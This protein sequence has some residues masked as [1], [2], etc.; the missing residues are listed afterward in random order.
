MNFTYTALHSMRKNDCND[1]EYHEISLGQ[2][3]THLRDVREKN[4]TQI[5]IISPYLNDCHGTHMYAGNISI[6]PLQIQICVPS[7]ISFKK[8]Y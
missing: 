6:A 5:S 4:L 7:R 2:H 3:S 1:L 8:W